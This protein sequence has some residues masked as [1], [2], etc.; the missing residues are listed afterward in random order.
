MINHCTVQSRKRQFEAGYSTLRSV[1]F[2]CFVSFM[3][4]AQSWV[5]A[6]GH[7]N[8]DKT[9]Q[10][11]YP[12]TSPFVDMSVG[13]AKMGPEPSRGIYER[14]MVAVRQMQSKSFVPY[15]FGGQHVGEPRVCVACSACVNAKHLPA[16]S[17]LARLTQCPA[18]QSCGV[19]CSNFVNQI[20][21]RAGIKYPFG[22]TS[23]LLRASDAHLTL[24][25]GFLDMGREV[26]DAKPGDLVLFRDHVVMLL[27]MNEYEKTVDY[28]HASRGSKRTPAGGIELRRGFDLN[29]FQRQVVR[30]LRHRDLVAPDDA[31]TTALA[32]SFWNDVQRIL[33]WNS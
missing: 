9:E 31:S 33:F 19:D 22:D 17:T 6:A 4:V 29:R 2:V 16:D 12:T 26:R 27:S 14:L 30:I 7:I 15:V 5:L 18:C 3:L 1:L 20:Y 10:F 25:Y 21:E 24:K 13:L 32:S 28:I 8:G 23:S 11:G